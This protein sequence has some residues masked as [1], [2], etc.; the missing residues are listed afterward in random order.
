MVEDRRACDGAI[1]DPLRSSRH[2]SN[3]HYFALRVSPDQDDEQA[4]VGDAWVAGRPA[5]ALGA[6]RSGGVCDGDSNSNAR[7]DDQH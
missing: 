2:I 7:H 4:S 6:Q 3:R 5:S 1:L